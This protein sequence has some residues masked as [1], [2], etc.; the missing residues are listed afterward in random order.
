MAGYKYSSELKENMSKAVGTGLPISSKHSREICA[1]IRG[2]KINTAKKFLADVISLD[3]AVP[4]KRYIKEM[5]HRKGPMAAGR[6]PVK[7]SKHILDI[8]KSAEAN[9]QFKG[10]SIKNLLIKHISAQ[11]GSK[12]IRYGRR[13]NK[14]KRTH[15]EVILEEKK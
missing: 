10:L 11:K 3:A 1:K 6:F 2:L 7:A 13:Q 14:A 15:I 9:A 8:L 4:Y 5:P 12:T